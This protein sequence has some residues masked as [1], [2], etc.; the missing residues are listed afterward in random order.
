[1]E[2]GVLCLQKKVMV[3][4]R[5]NT[6]VTLPR[7]SRNWCEEFMA[8]SQEQLALLDST[9]TMGF[10]RWNRATDRVWA[11]V[12]ALQILEVDAHSALTFDTLFCAIHPADRAAFAHA[13]DA[14]ASSD[15]TIEM[16]LRVIKQDRETRWIR[17]RAHT[18]RDDN[19]NPARVAGCVFDESTQKRLEQALLNQKRQI[20][21]LT[22]VA[23][24][25]ALSGALAHELQQPLTSI[26]S[27]A[28]AAQLLAAA[29]APN[30]DELQNILRDI[31]NADKNA[32][33]IIR[34]LRSLLMRGEQE[35]RPLELPR[36]IDSVLKLIRSTLVE[37]GV[38]VA[39]T[40]AADLPRVLG[41]P[42]ALQQVLLN[43][44]LNASDA[45]RAND[46]GDRHIE[47]IIHHNAERAELCTSVVDCGKGIEPEQ[48]TGMFEPFFTTKS[49]GLGLGLAVSRSIVGAHSGRLWTTNSLPRGAAFHF[50]LPVASETAVAI[51]GAA[52]DRA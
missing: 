24:L 23:M 2:S 36:I 5:P 38:S 17:I 51:N 1:M 43:L 45:M 35:A 30:I 31:V 4:H 34:H 40:F 32:G 14:N 44:I 39:T 12:H 27:N 19:A 3:D 28:Q 37:R 46:A 33:E 50:T 22:R 7:N 49:E 29:P 9:E 15:R 26:L 8:E 6:R 47:I 48:V 16:E 52:V 11:S 41:D 20:T 18:Y 13:L 25:G 10:W 21:H 42:I